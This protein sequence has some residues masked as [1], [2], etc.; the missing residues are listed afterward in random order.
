MDT[1]LK[2][3]LGKILGEIYRLQ[4]KEGL[5]NHSDGRIYGLI[6]GFESVIDEEMDMI[7]HITEKELKTVTDV[8]HEIDQNEEETEKF[9]G[10][11]DI[12]RKLQEKGIY[13]HRVIYIL[14]YLYASGRFTRLIDKMNSSGS[15]G[16]VR[17]LKL[18]DWEI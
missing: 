18:T 6:N 11:Y 2:L 9:Q 15:P 16:E 8:L 14:K 4:K 1:D 7:P 12:E 3:F 10:F 5:Y 13:R 17:N